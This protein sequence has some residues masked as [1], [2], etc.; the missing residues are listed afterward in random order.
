ME[1]DTSVSSIKLMNQDLVKL[2]QF[3][4]TNF[5]RWHDKLKFLLTMLKIF[6]ILDPELEPILEPND[7]DTESWAQE[8]A[9]GRVDMSWKH[10]QRSL[11]SSLQPLHVHTIDKGYLKRARV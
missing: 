3:D 11:G 9:R 4:G 7:K 8:E 6:Y 5:T 2:D 10:L 1:T